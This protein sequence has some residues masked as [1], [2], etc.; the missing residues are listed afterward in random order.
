MNK[1]MYR[2]GRLR[3]LQRLEGYVDKWKEEREVLGYVA[4]EVLAE[5]VSQISREMTNILDDYCLYIAG[6]A[7]SDAPFR[8]SGAG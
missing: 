3:A 6:R 1:E 4:D 8:T 7:N 5:H 2:E